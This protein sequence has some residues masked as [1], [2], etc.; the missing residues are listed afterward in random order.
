MR[1][2]VA[3]L[4]IILSRSPTFWEKSD[5]YIIFVCI[6]K[7]AIRRNRLRLAGDLL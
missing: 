1:P 3:F 6:S 5:H 4:D 2:C 7:I